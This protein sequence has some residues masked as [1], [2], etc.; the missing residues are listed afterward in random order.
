MNLEGFPSDLHAI[1]VY[2]LDD[3]GLIEHMQ[4]L[5]DWGYSANSM[6]LPLP[7]L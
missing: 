5:M 1:V 7:L 3:D 6:V 2:R 4:I